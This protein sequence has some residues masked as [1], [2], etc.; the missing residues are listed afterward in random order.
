MGHI[1]QDEGKIDS[2]NYYFHEVIKNG[3]YRKQCYAYY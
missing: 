2:A 3:D 1:Y